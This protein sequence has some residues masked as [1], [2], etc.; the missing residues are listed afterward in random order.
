MLVID[1]EKMKVL[2]N[3]M[4]DRFVR[5]M[6]AHL[7]DV[8]PDVLENMSDAEIEALI[9]DGIDQAAGYDI[10]GEQVVA[11]F[12]D[13]TVS[14]GADFVTREEHSWMGPVLSRRDM[15]GSEKMDFVYS[16]LM[17]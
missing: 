12:I 17:D 16:R 4:M 2:E 5:K 14:L 6:Q 9:R 13:L 1:K 7:Q 3:A 10:V 8:F 11:L 15:A